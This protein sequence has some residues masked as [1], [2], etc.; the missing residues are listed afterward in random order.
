MAKTFELNSK[1]KNFVLEIFDDEFALV[2]YY[3]V[4]W[5]ESDENETNKFVLRFAKSE[6]YRPFYQQ[7]AALLVEMGERKGARKHYFS[8]HED[9]A[10]ALPPKGTFEINGI[11]I[12]FYGNPLRLYCTRLNDNMVVLFNGG[13]KTA[14]T[15]QASDD[16]AQKFREAQHFARKIWEA[17]QD[18]TILIEKIT[19]RIMN[20]DGTEH[21]ILL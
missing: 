18:K 19:H 1:V 16:L 13:L 3:S 14:Q 9:A 21:D 12:N 7:I 5:D 17:V 8:R 4:R 11:E 10:S 20:F 6:E 2:T 15:A